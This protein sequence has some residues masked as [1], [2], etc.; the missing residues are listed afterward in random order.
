MSIFVVNVIY[1]IAV[2]LTVVGSRPISG[3][4]LS[5]MISQ[6]MSSLCVDDR[7]FM[8][9]LP[10][11]DV[12]GNCL[13]GFTCPAGLVKSTPIEGICASRE[14]CCVRGQY[15]QLRW[16]VDLMCTKIHTCLI[17]YSIRMIFKSGTEIQYPNLNGACPLRQFHMLLHSQIEL[18]ISFKNTP[19]PACQAGRQF[20]TFYDGLWYDPTGART[21]DLVLERRTR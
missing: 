20:A 8:A 13:P 15:L 5:T 7:P 9:R 3:H 2:I 1:S 18:L 19:I 11:A 6:L 21:H 16:Y 10:C 17:A 14:I 12:G 4:R